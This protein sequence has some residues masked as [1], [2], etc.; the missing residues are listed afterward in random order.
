MHQAHTRVHK[1]P[2]SRLLLETVCYS[3][4]LDVQQL[5]RMSVFSYPLLPDVSGPHGRAQRLLALLRAGH[6]PAARRA[7]ILTACKCL[8]S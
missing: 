2:A 4:M 8:R 1:T 7:S 6:G 3:R 5:A